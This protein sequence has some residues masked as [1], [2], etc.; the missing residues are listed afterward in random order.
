MG[1][2]ADYQRA[3]RRQRRWGNV[4]AW[5]GDLV[6]PVFALVVAVAFLTVVLVTS[7]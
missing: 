5:V 2:D 3:Y 6:L 7:S 4:M 1:W